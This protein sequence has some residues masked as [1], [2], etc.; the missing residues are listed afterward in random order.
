[1]INLKNKKI[2][3]ICGILPSKKIQ[4]IDNPNFDEKTK[5][6]IIRLSGIKERYI[7]DRDKNENILVFINK[8]EI[9]WLKSKVGIKMKS[10]GL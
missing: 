9:M 10:R 5:N 2:S 4:N 3:Y 7:L 6:K 8:P 1:M